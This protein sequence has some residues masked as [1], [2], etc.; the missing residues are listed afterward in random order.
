MP[1]TMTKNSMLV[2]LDG[3]TKLVPVDHYEVD[4]TYNLRPVPLMLPGE[5]LI[6]VAGGPPHIVDEGE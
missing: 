4:N 6:Q 3:E 2:V 1:W 5:R